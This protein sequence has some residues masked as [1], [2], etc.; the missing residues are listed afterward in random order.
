[1]HARVAAL[2]T[3]QA[4]LERARAD[5]E[6]GQKLVEKGAMSREDFDRR[7]QDIRT[8][9][10]TVNQ[11]LEEIYQVRAALGVS[12]KPERDQDLTDVPAD[13]VET[14]SDVRAAFSGLV[15]TMAQL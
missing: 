14:F 11:A 7:R 2:R 10:A 4:T 1:L 12:P 8:A 13:I 9:E 15:Q 6:R 5:Y 3:T